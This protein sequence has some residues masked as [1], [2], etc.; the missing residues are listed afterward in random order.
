MLKCVGKIMYSLWDNIP[1]DIQHYILCISRVKA[2]REKWKGYKN[3]VAEDVFS[4]INLKIFSP[5]IELYGIDGCKTVTAINI[6]KNMKY[7]HVHPYHLAHWQF[8]LHELSYQLWENEWVGGG[9][10]ATY[11]LIEQASLDFYTN[12]KYLSLSSPHESHIQEYP[13][14]DERYSQLSNNHFFDFTDFH[15]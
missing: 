9:Q 5:S 1:Y 12:P 3:R 11:N 15:D 13:H 10:A 6:I 14:I 7:F 8:F 4:I 2:A